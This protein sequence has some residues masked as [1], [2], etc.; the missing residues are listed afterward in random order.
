[1]STKD[2]VF[3]NKT[4]AIRCGDITMDFNKPKVM[5]VLNLTPDS[6]YDG[7]KYHQEKERARQVEKML[8]EGVDIIDLGAISSQPG[9]ADI[10]MEEEMERIIWPLQ[11]LVKT[12]PDA[13]FSIDTY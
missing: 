5:G 6:F 1:M 12:F 7:G 9:A 4:K 8:K 10:S 3:D 11:R 2:T 13:I